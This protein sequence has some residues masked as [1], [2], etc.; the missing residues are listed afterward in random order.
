MSLTKIIGTIALIGAGAGSVEYCIRQATPNEESRQ[1]LRNWALGIG[2][3]AV[4]AAIYLAKPYSSSTDE[5]NSNPPSSPS[6]P[7]PRP[8]RYKET[9]KE[10]YDKRGKHYRRIKKRKW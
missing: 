5:S 6:N 8:E 4:I 1:E 7:N 2:G 3:S 10:G 9:I